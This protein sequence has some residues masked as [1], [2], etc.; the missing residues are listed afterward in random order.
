M[1]ETVREERIG[2]SSTK[3]R[4]LIQKRG[5]TRSIG[6]AADAAGDVQTPPRGSSDEI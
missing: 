1:G 6:P 4:R 3:R 2:A 5:G